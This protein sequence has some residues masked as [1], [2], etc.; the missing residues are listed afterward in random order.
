MK[1]IPKPIPG[2][3]GFKCT[4]R[5]PFTKKVSSYGLGTQDQDAAEATCND[6][7]LLFEADPQIPEGSPRLLAY[8]PRAVEIVYGKKSASEVFQHQA[9]PTLDPSDVGTLSTRILAALTRTAKAKQKATLDEILSEY[10]SIRYNELN[11]QYE[12]LENRLKVLEPK[13]QEQSRYI[14][15]LRREH[16]VHVTITVADAYHLW[17]QTDD[18]KALSGKTQRETIYAIDSFT[19]SLPDSKAFKLAD[20]K[21]NHITEWL[22]KLKAKDGK[23]ELSVVTKAKMKRYLSVF[24]GAAY[25]DHD[26]SENPMDK[27]KAIKGAAMNREQITAITKLDHFTEMLDAVKAVD[28]YWHTLLATAVLA[29]P[30]YAELCWMKI[31]HVNLE[32]NY[33]RIA[34]REDV[35]GEARGTKTGRERSVPIENTVLRELL[36]KHVERRLKEQKQKDATEA[37][38]S[39][40]L[41]PTTVPGNPFK[42][43]TLTPEGVWSDNGIFLDE[44]RAV[45][46][47]ARAK[48]TEKVKNE[49]KKAELAG[50]EY[51]N[52][53]PREWRHCAGTAMGHA[54]NDTGRVAAWLGNSEDVC[55]R[56]YKRASES[57]KLWP[58]KW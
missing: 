14:D 32:G 25:S 10:E 9:K 29:G 36:E 31:E 6:L 49:H 4:F 27:T 47:K 53:G 23:S 48:L 34:T 22:N 30:R 38:K 1:I 7:V 43:R 20:L 2:Q 13:T 58:F 55:R 17:K 51:W 52:Y 40:Y 19:A 24:V 18:F 46:D 45:R 54:G 16:N 11:K 15:E 41:F 39:D 21:A 8:K 12:T 3:P 56:H 28:S 57:G 44:W 37:Q 50:R 42:P 5:L 26:L 35:D 33:I